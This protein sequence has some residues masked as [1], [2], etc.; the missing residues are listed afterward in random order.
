MQSLSARDSLA[1]PAC[2]SHKR[3]VGSAGA[4][5]CLILSV[6]NTASF[7]HT[8]RG[9]LGIRSGGRSVA[10]PRQIQPSENMET[11]LT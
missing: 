5:V 11:P 1:F 4:L 8:T 3:D 9:E 10:V 2:R 7:S 6:I